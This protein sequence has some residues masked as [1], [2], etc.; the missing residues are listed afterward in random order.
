MS[1]SIDGQTYS[2]VFTRIAADPR[3]DERERKIAA[4]IGGWMRAAGRRSSAMWEAAETG[5]Y[6][7]WERLDAEALP[8]KPFVGPSKDDPSG[9][10]E[11]VFS[12]FACGS[13]VF[14]VY[15]FTT[16]GAMNVTVEDSEVSA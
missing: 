3:F 9:F 10:D 8:R 11:T 4:D 5:D 12:S 2:E 13:I 6:D 7:E 15:P 1:L 16:V 14:R